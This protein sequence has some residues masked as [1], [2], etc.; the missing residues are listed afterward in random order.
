MNLNLDAYDSVELP[1]ADAAEI[2]AWALR[3]VKAMYAL[4]ILQG[5]SDGGVL[6]CNAG[7]TISRAE[8]MTILGRTQARGYAET[9]LA[10]ADADQVPAWAAPFVRSLVGQGVVNGYNNLI[11]P[12]NPITRGEVAKMLYAML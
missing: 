2:P 6:R 10:F 11:Q 7:A 1:F 5:T 9:E 3:E 8:A 4:G 12:L